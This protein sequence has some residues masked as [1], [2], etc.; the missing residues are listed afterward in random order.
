M[1]PMIFLCLCV[2][3]TVVI[4]CRE[5]TWSFLC[6]I[7]SYKGLNKHTFDYVGD[8]ITKPPHQPPKGLGPRTKVCWGY[9]A[10]A[11]LCK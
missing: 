2:H 6:K 1:C 4:E 8:T 7:R 9:F 11:P 3:V 5:G 10:R